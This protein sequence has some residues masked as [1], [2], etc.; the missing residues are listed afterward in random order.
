MLQCNERQL[1]T[2]TMTLRLVRVKL[3]TETEVLITN[4]MDTKQYPAEVVKDLYY[5]RWH[6][7]EPYKRQKQWLDIENFSGKSVPSLRQDFHARQVTHNLTAML[8]HASHQQVESK[9]VTHQHAYKI[10]F[11]QALSR[12]KGNV[13][14]LLMNHDL[15]LRI[16]QLL[17]YFAKT[18]GAV[19]R[20]RHFARHMSNLH[21]MTYKACR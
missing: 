8:A 16:K 17:H 11:A 7:E 5:P 2:Q 15:A 13:V 1:P 12:M 20:E 18:T 9:P 6:I 21:H 3:K 14:L 4:R 10:N 19:R